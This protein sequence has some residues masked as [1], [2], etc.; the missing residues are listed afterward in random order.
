MNS[1]NTRHA[2]TVAVQAVRI[3][4]RYC[5]RT[6]SEKP[7]SFVCRWLGSSVA[8][9]CRCLQLHVEPADLD[10]VEHPVLVAVGLA[11]AGQLRLDL[12]GPSPVRADGRR[13]AGRPAFRWPVARDTASSVWSTS[14][15]WPRNWSRTIR[16]RMGTRSRWVS[17]KVLIAQPA[18]LAERDPQIAHVPAQ[19]GGQRQ[20]AH[21]PLR[22]L[23]RLR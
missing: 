6:S 22:L 9:V 21:P 10:V 8:S 13:C 7:A 14:S 18:Q 23:T 4:T 19:L 11:D 2:D 3:S 1:R 5:P 16:T 15:N 20:L 12:V 17:G